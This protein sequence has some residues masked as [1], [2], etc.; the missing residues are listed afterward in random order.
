[1][2][3]FHR[4]V[5]PSYANAPVLGVGPATTA[6][7]GILYNRFNVTSGGTGGG[8]SAFM[9]GA[10]GA[11]PNVGTYAVAFGEDASSS[12]ANRGLRAVLENTDYLD[13]LFHRDIAIPLVTSVTVAGGGGDPSIVLPAGTFVGDV[14]T[15]PINMLFELVDSQDRELINNT[16]GNKIYVASIAGAA[17]GDGF[18]AGLVTLNFSENVPAGTVYKVYYSSRGNLATM[19][20]DSLSYIRV[21]GAQ[22][23]GAEV[24]KVLMK[25]HGGSQAWNAN[26][27]ITI[28]DVSLSVDT[29]GV[30]R[31]H[32]DNPS[33]VDGTPLATGDLRLAANFG[34]YRLNKAVGPYVGPYTLLQFTDFSGNY[35]WQNTILD[36]VDNPGGVA[37]LDAG[38]RLNPVAQRIR[39]IG[40][41][42]YLPFESLTGLQRYDIRLV[43]GYGDADLGYGLYWWDD[44]AV[45]PTVSPWI[46]EPA[47][48]PASGR[49]INSLAGMAGTAGGF[50]TLDSLS[51]VNQFA[52]Y[53]DY[54]NSAPAFAN[55]AAEPVG[56]ADSRRA[57]VVPNDT[58]DNGLNGL[59]VYNPS[60][61]L[62][63]DNL[64]WFV[65]STGGN[66]GGWFHII[67]GI[68]GVANGVATLDA[69]A[70]LP[71]AQ[72]PSGSV[73]VR[74]SKKATAAT[75]VTATGAPSQEIEFI[76]ITTTMTTDI[77]V[78]ALVT[79]WTAA[80]GH[81]LNLAIKIGAD[82]T[83]TSGDPGYNSYTGPGGSTPEVSMPLMTMKT[84]A[85]AGT[86][87]IRILASADVSGDANVNGWA[88]FVRAVKP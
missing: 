77:E 68:A 64:P 55:L 37:G 88:F 69:G 61:T 31:I 6:F 86:Y 49:W 62:V 75:T 43:S 11:G 45:G 79:G 41:L 72:L 26:W 56:F 27:D 28:H 33:A 29:L 67:S 63:A 87:T 22:E 81:T 2:T 46:I 1:M 34:I 57:Y 36:L 71:V 83:P 30:Y 84:G 60:T 10:K 17:I 7:D 54:F 21:R 40:P 3:T 32:E 9:D 85:A 78:I 23:V 5:D 16:T 14:L 42:A 24:E 80:G 76:T 70:K 59:Y 73:V 4:F 53:I 38:G 35:V 66:P 18:S 8:G 39:T 48:L 74:S 50:A 44:T 12:N 82:A 47:S 13:D 65:K 25:L 15:Y 19:P 58:A 51:R 20:V 52:K